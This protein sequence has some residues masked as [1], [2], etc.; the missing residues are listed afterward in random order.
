MK[1]LIRAGGRKTEADAA[2]LLEG[3][4]VIPYDPSTCQITQDLL[5]PGSGLRW[6]EFIDNLANAYEARFEA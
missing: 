6:H 5:A 1:R 4:P 2:H 3:I